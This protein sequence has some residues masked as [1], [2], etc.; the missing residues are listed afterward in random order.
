MQL[1]KSKATKRRIIREK[2]NGE[3]STGRKTK[4][5]QKAE[6]KQMKKEKNFIYLFI[7]I[8]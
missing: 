1:Q 2:R 5:H 6:A 3:V 8:K 7:F 4:K